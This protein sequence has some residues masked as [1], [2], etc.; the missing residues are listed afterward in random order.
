MEEVVSGGFKALLLLMGM[1]LFVAL[2][3]LIGYMADKFHWN[4]CC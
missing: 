4:W 3:A 2:L 1:F